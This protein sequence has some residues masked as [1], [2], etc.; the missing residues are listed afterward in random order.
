MSASKKLEHQPM[1]RWGEKD[2]RGY[3][4][5]MAGRTIAKVFANGQHTKCEHGANCAHHD[6]VEEYW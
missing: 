5:G 2:A 3:V 4:I 1:A 6:G